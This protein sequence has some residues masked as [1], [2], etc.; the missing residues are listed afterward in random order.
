MTVEETIKLLALVKLAYPEAYKGVDAET[1][2]A[3]ISMWHKHFNGAPYAIMETALDRFVK[4]SKFA[5]K[6]AD[7]YEELRRLNGEAFSNLFVTQDGRRRDALLYILENTKQFDER[8]VGEICVG[9]VQNIL[10]GA[11]QPLIGG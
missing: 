11:S 6:V 7:I 5:P 1:L 4:R 3:T 9:E 10:C 8:H 2:N